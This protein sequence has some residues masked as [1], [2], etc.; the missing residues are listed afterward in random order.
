MVYMPVAEA[1]LI[2]KPTNPALRR[3]Q[4]AARDERA[5]TVT[6]V[7]NIIT[8]NIQSGAHVAGIVNRTGG[9]EETGL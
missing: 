5:Q 6:N 3:Q 8:Q 1:V 7:I 9:P 2:P 4:Q